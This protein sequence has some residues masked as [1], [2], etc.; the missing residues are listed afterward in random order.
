MICIKHYKNQDCG[1]YVLMMTQFGGCEKSE[2]KI[3]FVKIIINSGNDRRIPLDMTPPYS[4]GGESVKE[5]A[6]VALPRSSAMLFGR[7]R[8]PWMFP[9]SDF[10]EKTISDWIAFVVVSL[11]RD[12]VK[13]TRTEGGGGEKFTKNIKLMC[14]THAERGKSFFIFFICLKWCFRVEFVF[15][16]SDLETRYSLSFGSAIITCF[17]GVAGSGI[18][19]DTMKEMIVR[20]FNEVQQKE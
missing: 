3:G 11:T 15:L 2:C 1:T 14:Y 20:N 12:A 5:N 9:L 10:D 17:E 6:I 4:F 8:S 13:W 7:S 16:L 19:V 18:S